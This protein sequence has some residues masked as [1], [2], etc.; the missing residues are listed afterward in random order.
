MLAANMADQIRVTADEINCLVYAFLLDS[1]EKLCFVILNL[2]NHFQAFHT[3]RLLY[4][5]R[6]SWIAPPCS[7]NTSFADS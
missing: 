5:P 2:A 6:L 4:A 3:L 1:G 7:I